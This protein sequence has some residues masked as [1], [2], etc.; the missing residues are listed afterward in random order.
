[1][2]DFERMVRG[3]AAGPVRRLQ[4]TGSLAGDEAPVGHDH[5]HVVCRS[6]GAVADVD[7]AVGCTPCPTAAEDSSDGG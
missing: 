2:S 6:W 5:H 4:P 7:R 3:A 1:M